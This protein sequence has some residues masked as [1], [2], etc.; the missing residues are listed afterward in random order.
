[1]L[2]DG[3]VDI[4]M[5]TIVQSARRSYKG[6]WISIGSEEISVKLQP[7][8]ESASAKHSVEFRQE[9]TL[10]IRDSVDEIT[11]C[12]GAEETLL[13]QILY[14]SDRILVKD[15]AGNL[16]LEAETGDIPAAGY[17]RIG[18]SKDFSG[19]LD[20]LQYEH[21]EIERSLPPREQRIVSY[22]NWVATDDLGRSVAAIPRPEI[23]KRINTSGFSILFR[24]ISSTEEFTITRRLI[25]RAAR[26]PVGA[27]GI[28]PCWLRQIL[29]GAVFWILYQ[30]RHVGLQETRISADRSGR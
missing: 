23:R 24:L 21:T 6:I 10:V 20:N 5:R 11:I 29:G 18:G 8:K 2:E 4:G 17:L 9:Q 1:M 14:S 19:T 22:N 25:S 7:S 28:W 26:R 27:A 30:R 12:A 13:M 15:G 16:L 3:T